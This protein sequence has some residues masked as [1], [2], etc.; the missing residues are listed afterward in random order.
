M[1]KKRESGSGWNWKSLQERQPS[2][3]P[4]GPLFFKRNITWSEHQGFL[5]LANISII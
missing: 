3:S 1:K 5:R 2:W 4:R